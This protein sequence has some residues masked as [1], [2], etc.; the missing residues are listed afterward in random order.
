[1]TT[2]KIEGRNEAIGDAIEMWQERGIC[3]ACIDY[4]LRLNREYQDSYD[5]FALMHDPDDCCC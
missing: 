4:R 5:D 2:I 3:R 1:M